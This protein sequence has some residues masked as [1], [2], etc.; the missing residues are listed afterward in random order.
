MLAVKDRAARVLQ[1]MR[2]SH[3]R[4]EGH[5]SQL[6]TLISQLES[7]LGGVDALL[8][9][10]AEMEEVITEL[11]SE[12]EEATTGILKR[13]HLF[14]WREHSISFAATWGLRY[15][16]LQGHTLSYFGDEKDRHPRKT[17]DLVNCF[18]LD[19]GLTKNSRYHIF[20]ICSKSVSEV[21]R[22]PHSGALLRLS[23]DNEAEAMQWILMLE[24][25]CG[26]KNSSPP[27]RSKSS[28]EVN[29]GN[30]VLTRVQSSEAMLHSISEKRKTFPIERT[31]SLGFMKGNEGHEAEVDKGKQKNYIKKLKK[32]VHVT[33][34][35]ASKNIHISSKYSPLSSNATRQNYRGFFNLAVI[36][37]LLSHFRL[38]VDNFLSHGFRFSS[39]F[40]YSVEKEHIYAW[41]VPRPLLV[42]LSWV[43][44]L[45]LTYGVE[46]MAQYDFVSDRLTMVIQ[47]A[48]SFLNI[49]ISALWVWYS[50]S[51]P[52]L[53]MAYLLQSVILWMKMISYAHCNRDLRIAHRNQAQASSQVDV[54]ISDV[55]DIQ[56]SPIAYPE[57]LNVSNLA[58]FCVAPTLCY[59]LNYPRSRDI[60]WGVV[61]SIVVRIVIVL[62]L[63]LFVVEQIMKPSLE[64]AMVPMKNFD[65][66]AILF[67]FLQLTLPSTYVWLLGFYLVFHLWLNFLAELTKFGDREFYLDWWNARTI[68]EYWRMWNLP[69]H[70]WM[71][72]HLYYPSIRLGISKKFAVYIA[73]F[74]SAFFHEFII[75]LPFRRISFHAFLGMLLQAPL[76]PVTRKL[77]ALFNNPSIGNV[78]F[79]I[80]F[81]IIGQP[82]GIIM[83]YY[84]SWEVNCA[85]G[86]CSIDESQQTI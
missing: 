24:K 83:Y 37:L 42:L 77:N 53:C 82:I 46:K 78:F 44:F 31:K 62:V 76:V 14:K 33:S 66:M 32:T 17:I 69:V 13:G 60:R 23:S 5:L 21:N 80:S 81:C 8:R 9:Q 58:Y 29:G 38:I 41:D 7:Q 26:F 72:R 35:P 49:C 67:R 48:I 16:T 47:G 75:S 39:L 68:D 30:A 86:Y 3:E 74:F 28:Q 59:Q 20:S 51:H 6:E 57:N 36:V 54:E 10:N 1:E 70:H 45:G 27:R 52:G 19:E 79:W 85:A 40:D 43:S 4:E 63:M 15:F 64:A 56:G 65:V 12:L 2:Q 71:I 11:S 18:I 73:F 34:Y 61:L 22:G 84:E 50:N 25:A 55:K